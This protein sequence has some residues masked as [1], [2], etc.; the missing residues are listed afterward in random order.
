MNFIS[1]LDEQGAKKV[2]TT[3]DCILYWPAMLDQFPETPETPLEPC[4]T[5]TCTCIVKEW[6]FLHVVEGKGGIDGVIGSGKGILGLP[7]VSYLALSSL[8]PAPSLLPSF[9]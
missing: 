4:L 7:S 8:S 9:L 1:L 5:C 2:Y 6:S 3:R